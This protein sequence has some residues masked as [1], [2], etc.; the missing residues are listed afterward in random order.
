MF[1]AIEDITTEKLIAELR[2]RQIEGE[3]KILRY[4]VWNVFDP[5]DSFT[6]DASTDEL[7]AFAALDELGWSV[8][9]EPYD[10]ADDEEEDT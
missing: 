8:S 1:D 2:R 10:P 5:N 7:A 6:V 9:G 4:Q 3:L